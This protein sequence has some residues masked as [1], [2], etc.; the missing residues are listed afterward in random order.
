MFNR[1]VDG[2]GF[3]EHSTL[4]DERS[5]LRILLWKPVLGVGPVAPIE[6]LVAII[7]WWLWIVW[8]R[9]G[10]VHEF[11]KRLAQVLKFGAWHSTKL[12][13]GIAW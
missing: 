5:E 2:V 9:R 12:R 8:I 6:H 11:L 1:P 10:F 3:G 13:S 4:F 7:E